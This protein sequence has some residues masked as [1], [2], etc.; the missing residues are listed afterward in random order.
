MKITPREKRLHA[1][2]R[3]KNHFSLSSPPLSSAVDRIVPLVHTLLTAS[4]VI[5][6]TL[7]VKHAPSLLTLLVTLKM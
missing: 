6:F 1:A 3:E 5:L 4:Q 2:R 7:Q